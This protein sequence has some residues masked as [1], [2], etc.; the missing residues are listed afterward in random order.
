MHRAADPESFLSLLSK[1]S[2]SVEPNLTRQ[3]LPTSSLEARQAL[4][5]CQRV[6]LQ[7]N[8]NLMSLMSD[9]KGEKTMRLL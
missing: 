4:E 1:A 3:D 7:M 6:K 9:T 2:E 5:L 8:E